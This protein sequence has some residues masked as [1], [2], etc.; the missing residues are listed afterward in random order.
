MATLK[1]EIDLDDLQDDVYN[2][3]SLSKTIVNTIRYEVAKELSKTCELQ[4]NSEIK[5][6]S[7]ARIPNMVETTLKEFLEEKAFQ[8]EWGGDKVDFKAWMKDYL[9]RNVQ[10]TY[11]NTA[12]KHIDMLAANFVKEL[13]ERYD[14][15]FA[16]HIVK[17]MAEQKLLKDDAIAKLLDNKK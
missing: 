13:K 7:R 15:Q 12:K 9:T 5:E 2:G 17:N 1:I 4:I 11:T 10:N 3:E 14:L 16:A 8:P 6:L